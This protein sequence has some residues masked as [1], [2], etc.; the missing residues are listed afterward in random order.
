MSHL[1]PLVA[2]RCLTLVVLALLLFG[3]LPALA[4]DAGNE[5]PV[6]RRTATLT[7]S[8]VTPFFDA[9][10]LE[11]K[12]RA[13]K[14]FAVVVN[15]SYLSIA[16]ADWTTRAGTIGAGADYFFQGDALRRWYVEAI[17]EVWFTSPRH[18]PSGTVAG[19]ALGYAGFALVGYQFVFDFGAVLDLGVGVVAFHL[20]RATVETSGG[21]ASSPAATTV[22]PAGKLNVGWAF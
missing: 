14:G 21:S 12:V 15:A 3:S 11:G 2:K 9:Y 20:P 7:T 4:A 16:K 19:F 10:Y 1:A 6:P 18:D 5:P 8:L 13:P 17:G 22:Y